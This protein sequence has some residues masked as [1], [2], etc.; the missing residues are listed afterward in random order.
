MFQRNHIAMLSNFFVQQTIS[1]ILI[2]NKN[3]LKMLTGC[4]SLLYRILYL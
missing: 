1:G 2:F 4:T 3:D